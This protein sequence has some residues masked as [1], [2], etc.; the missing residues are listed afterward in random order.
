MA[1][2]EVGI[3]ESRAKWVCNWIGGAL[4]DGTVQVSDFRSVLGRLSFTLGA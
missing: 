1:T 3:S 2:Y 4:K